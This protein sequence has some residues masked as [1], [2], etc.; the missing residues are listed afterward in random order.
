M[1]LPVCLQISRS[2]SP[3]K[4]HIGCLTTHDPKACHQSEQMETHGKQEKLVTSRS[5]PQA[6]HRNPWQWCPGC[7]TVCCTDVGR[8]AV[9]KPVKTQNLL[10]A[11]RKIQKN[12]LTRNTFTCSFSRKLQHVCC[13]KWQFLLGMNARGGGVFRQMQIFL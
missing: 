9:N 10:E 13:K 5:L 8:V 4:K 2:V 11:T 7:H 6:I 12:W 3:D 1:S